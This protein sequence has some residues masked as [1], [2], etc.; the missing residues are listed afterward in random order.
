[1]EKDSLSALGQK[2]AY[3]ERNEVFLREII[4]EFN[5][6]PAIAQVLVSR[7]F[8]SIQKIRD[9]LDP[10]LSELHPTNLFLDMEKAVAR[11]LLAKENNE[12]VMIYGDSDV[13]GITGVTLLVE[14][15]QILG[16]KTSYCCSG[17]LFKQ[18]GETSSLISQMLQDR[19]S[20]LIT[21]DC[22][23]T[24]GKEVQAMNKQGIDV[25]VTDHHMPTGK[26]PHCVAMLNPKLDKNPYPNKELTGVGVAFKL[27][28]ATYEEL[29]KQ[30][31]SWT[32]KIDLVRFLDLVSLG[33]IADVGRLSGENRILVAYGIKEIAKGKRLGLKRLC[34][35][36]GVD[37]CEVSSTNLGIRI[38]PKLNSLGRLA[39]S[40]QGVRLLL[41]QDSRAIGA[42]V[43]ELATVNQ[44]RQRIEAEVLRDVERILAANPKLTAQAAI[45][46][47]SPNWHS[48]V[49]PIISARLARTYNKPVAIIA[50]QN[51]VGK[52][53][54]RTI[55]SFPLLGVLRKCEPFFLSY[56]GH[57]FA[58]GLMIKEDQVE[59]FRKKFIHLV[60]SSLRK[61]EAMRTLP[62]DVDMDFSH[63]NRDLISSMELLEPFGKGNLSPVFYTK[64][65]QVRYPKLLP[66]NHVK[67]YLNSGERNLEGTAFGQGDKIS[68]L[69]ANWNMPL[70]IAY[71]LRVTRRSAHGAV[72]LLI[73]DFRI[74]AS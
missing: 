8:Q 64:A 16:V 28:S 69:K 38:T 45:V 48:R 59:G 50:L 4:K 32:D 65:I 33:T 53:S 68:L 54:L 7:G 17:T 15:L 20:L 9:F 61:D 40:D 37:K 57:D 55:G 21:V 47:A 62:L 12:H 25:I 31:S 10:Q 46:L 42:I 5:L 35:L 39:D 23:V 49:I 58:A 41:S 11:L 44:E 19:V 51:G 2:W 72:R 63:I 56:G 14:F 29:I 74:L 6:H 66:G 36:S 70:E 67:L 13:D 27:V 26:L 22:G 3:P 34:S 18:H 73:Q 24:A 43:S 30:D 52:G 71:T 1:M 60:S